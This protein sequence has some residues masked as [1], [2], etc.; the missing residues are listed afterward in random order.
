M[1]GFTGFKTAAA[2]EVPHAVA[3]MDPFHVTR[4][5]G[6]AVD[7]CRR[8][9]QQELHG[10]RGRKTD[11]LYRA[12][13]TLHTGADL[14]TDKQQARLQLLFAGDDHVQVEATWGIYQRMIAAYRDPD[15]A[16]G[17]QA[18][19]KIIEAVSYGV[20][21]ALFELRRLGRTMKQRAADILAYFDRPGTSNGPTEAINGR[22]EHL[23]GSALGFRNLTNYIAR[24][25]L[26]TGGFRPRLHR[27]F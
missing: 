16:R 21:A 27:E 1:D 14:L 22:L 9:V 26:E 2:E 25:L 23:R 4:L 11:P 13:P 20:P 6:E 18:M 15:R 8:R 7:L 24:S 19:T 12:R 17:R 3:V 5:A 10:H